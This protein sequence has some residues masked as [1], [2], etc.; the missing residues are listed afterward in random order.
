MAGCNLSFNE[1]A[2]SLQSESGSFL[3]V[4]PSSAWLSEDLQRLKIFVVNEQG[5]ISH[6]LIYVQARRQKKI[7][8][9]EK[10]ND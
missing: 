6:V 1:E 2:I 10:E 9:K 5:E 8:E 4:V 3:G 7:K